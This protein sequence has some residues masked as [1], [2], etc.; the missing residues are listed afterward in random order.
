VG[1]GGKQ[2]GIYLADK[3]KVGD[4]N[5]TTNNQGIKIKPLN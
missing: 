1:F 3:I 2:K 4:H 5:K